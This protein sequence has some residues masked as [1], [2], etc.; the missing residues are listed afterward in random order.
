MKRT[1]IF[2]SADLGSSLVSL[3]FLM[4]IHWISFEPSLIYTRDIFFFALQGF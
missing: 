2:E 4:I 1:K 3:A